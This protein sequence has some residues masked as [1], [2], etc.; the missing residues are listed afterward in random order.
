MIVWLS[1]GISECVCAPKIVN[2]WLSDGHHTR[3]AAFYAPVRGRHP[4]NTLRQGGLA[5]MCAEIFAPGV[6]NRC[7]PDRWSYRCEVMS[8]KKRLRLIIG[9]VLPIDSQLVAKHWPLI[10][11]GGIM[12]YVNNEIINIYGLYVGPKWRRISH[13]ECELNAADMD[14]T[15]VTMGE[16]A[17]RRAVSSTKHTCL[18]MPFLRTTL[19]FSFY[20]V[21]IFGYCPR[22]SQSI[23][24]RVRN[25]ETST[26]LKCR[27]S[28][29]TFTFLISIVR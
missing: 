23:N 29:K 12:Q 24:N 17:W 9:D 8:L 2:R 1:S 10:L 7:M 14:K 5:P 28:Y 13:Q 4:Q 18:N 20:R 25:L 15:A 22:V 27:I 3:C 11:A 19:V 21:R 6:T 26:R 16:T